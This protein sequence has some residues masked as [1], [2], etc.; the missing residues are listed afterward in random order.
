MA[1]Y[2]HSG[3]I[4]EKATERA[5]LKIPKQGVAKGKE[6][7]GQMNCVACHVGVEPLGESKSPESAKALTP[8]P[9]L[10]ALNANHGCLADKQPTGI[11]R[12]D[13]ND[14]QKRALRLAIA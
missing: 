5:A 11:P 2:L 1:A 14:L 9:A 12:Y 3:R 10:A 6:I 13:L 8:T 7:F 4:A